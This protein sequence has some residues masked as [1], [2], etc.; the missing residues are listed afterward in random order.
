MHTH[1][2]GYKVP[3]LA[4]GEETTVEYQMFFPSNL[5]PRDFFLHLRVMLTE[6]QMPSYNLIFNEVRGRAVVTANRRALERIP[7]STLCTASVRWRELT[8]TGFITCAQTISIIEGHK[9]I[10][11]ELLGLYAIL[12]AGL[13]AGGECWPRKHVYS[14][15]HNTT[16]LQQRSY[17]K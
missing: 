14:V 15:P 11:T 9:I 17:V 8:F 2:Q 4:A 16:S 7:C 12:L 13:A 10:D 6:G 3:Q 5:P 1:L